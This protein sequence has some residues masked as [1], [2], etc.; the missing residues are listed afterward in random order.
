MAPPQRVHESPALPR[1]LGRSLCPAIADDPPIPEGNHSARECS[2]FIGMRY[3]DDGD[4]M[5]PIEL[6]KNSHNLGTGMRIELACGLIGEKN[7]RI[8]DQRARNRYPLLLSPGELSRQAA[9]SSG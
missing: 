6:L 7:F 2:Y 5:S 9:F 8:V 3:H 1:R 4:A